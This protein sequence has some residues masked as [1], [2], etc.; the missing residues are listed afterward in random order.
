MMNLFLKKKD[1]STAET[2]EKTSA[3]VG[4]KKKLSKRWIKLVAI[5]LAVAV[6]GACFYQYK[7]GSSSDKTQK[8]EITALAQRGRVSSVIEGSGTIEALQQYE[9]TSLAKGEIKADYFEEGDMVEKDA[10]LYR[11]D[12]EAGY[13]AIDN[14]KSSLSKA[15][16]TYNNAIDDINNLV[17]KS[18]TQGV[19]STVYIQ[20]GDNIGANAKIADV[21]DNTSMILEIQFLESYAASM[22]EGASLAELVLSKNGTVLSGTV[23]KI[24]SGSVLSSVGARV[25]NVEITVQNP[26]AIKEGDIATAKVG[27]YACSSEGSFKNSGKGTI[28][29]KVSGKVETVNIMAGDSVYYGQNVAILSNESLTDMDET[30]DNLSEAQKN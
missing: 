8:G 26:G 2:T 22:T 1:T 18:D 29:S 17:V 23:S 11:M 13:D 7:F 16:R 28:Y 6:G 30:R 15:Q 4:F 14:A 10:I 12:D 25:T 5:V 3:A 24:S 27:E 19:V 21:I 20:K 9:I